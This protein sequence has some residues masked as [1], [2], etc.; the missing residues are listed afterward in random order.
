MYQADSVQ[1]ILFSFYNGELYK[2]CVTY[3]RSATEGLTADDMVKSISSKYSARANIALEIDFPANEKYQATQKPV[4]SWDNAQYSL[5]LVR[6]PFS[7]DFQLLIYS[8]QLNAAAE[9]ALAEAVKL[10][11][12][13][14]PQREAA[15]L[16]KVTGDSEVAREKNQKIFRP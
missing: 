15:R 6:S 1:E 5:D 14:G 9:I 12:Q 7:G 16:R 8:K 2:T 10:D 4:A 11:T 3:D 13:E